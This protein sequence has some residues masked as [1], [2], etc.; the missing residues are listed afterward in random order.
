[1]KGI[2]LATLLNVGTELSFGE[3]E[4][5]LV[6][7]LRQ[8]FGQTTNRTASQIVERQLNVQPTIKVRPGWPLRVIVQKDLVL[9][10]HPQK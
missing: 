10:P 1:M 9:S 6:E 7:A 4:N 8:G 2:A 3:D 5:D